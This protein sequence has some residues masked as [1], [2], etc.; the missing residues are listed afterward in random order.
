MKAFCLLAIVLTFYACTSTKVS[1]Q[2]ASG[3]TFKTYKDV[4]NFLI[5]YVR[6]SDSMAVVFRA[7]PPA[8]SPAGGIDVNCLVCIISNISTCKAEVCSPGNCDSDRIR[9]CAR[10]KCEVSGQCLVTNPKQWGIIRIL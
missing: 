6:V 2:T 8:G 3:Y 1:T 10:E 9:Q 7:Q 5:T 4:D